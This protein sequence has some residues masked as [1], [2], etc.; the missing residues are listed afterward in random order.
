MALTSRFFVAGT[1]YKL[2]AFEVGE[3]EEWSPPE[4]SQ[5][6]HVE[7][8]IE[9]GGVSGLY[10]WTLIPSSKMSEVVGGHRGA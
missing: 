6:M 3:G 1:T 8:I 5:V 7:P 10:L 2:C 9:E 4:G